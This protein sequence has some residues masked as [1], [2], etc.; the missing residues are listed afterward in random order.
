MRRDCMLLEALI[1]GEPSSDTPG[2]RI[3]AHVVSV[4]SAA[5]TR[6]PT[7]PALE[8][9]HPV[10]S[11]PGR[12]ARARRGARAV[13]AGPSSLRR[14]GLA[15]AGALLIAGCGPIVDRAAFPARP[16]SVRAGDL[17]G[18]FDGK[19]VDADTD[20]PIAGALVAASWAFERGIGEHGPLDAEES[21][22]QTGADGRY[23][24][25]R[26]GRL[27]TGMSSRIRRFTLIVYQRGY[28]AYRSD[29]RFPGRDARRDFSQRAN[30]VRL[31][32]WQ[33]TYAHGQHLLFM[34]G[35]SKLREA[36]AWEADQAGFDLESDE[37]ARGRER[38]GTARAQVMLDVSKITCEQF[39]GYKITTPQN[40]AIW[41]SGYYNG[42]QSNTVID[43][44]KF[45]ENTKALERYCIQNPQILVMKAGETVFGLEK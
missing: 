27:P 32:R 33:T 36:A 39:A 2:L 18:P 24:V 1:T 9:H 16:D 42:K 8:E 37:A 6:T 29:R 20:R 40:I 38:E 23:A 21:I 34:G 31:D 35:G 12:R 22:T 45:M 13:G 41:L 5:L 19:V 28:V 11:R 30:L 25:P 26:L 3:A 17:L 43:M 7:S 10:R 4:V 14:A 44:Q 15:A